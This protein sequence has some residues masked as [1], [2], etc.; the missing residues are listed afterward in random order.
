MYLGYLSVG[1]I[2]SIHASTL[3]IH[4]L[5]SFF[6]I[7]MY[8]CTGYSSLNQVG[9]DSLLKYISLYDFLSL[10][11]HKI[12]QGT[13]QN[14]TLEQNVK[15]NESQTL[16]QSDAST[17]Q[18]FF[19]RDVASIVNCSLLL[20]LIFIDDLCLAPFSAVFK[21]RINDAE[22]PIFFLY[23]ESMGLDFWHPSV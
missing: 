23:I 11:K 3:I 14:M 8:I 2:N 10:C 19:P 17:S 15:W 21:N 12:T 1:G 6:F 13:L 9:L 20:F 7:Y 16:S 18:Q 4:Q 22:V 5:A